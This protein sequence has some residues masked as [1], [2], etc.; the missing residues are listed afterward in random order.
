MNIQ[1][2][3]FNFDDQALQNNDIFKEFQF[4]GKKYF[5][6]FNSNGESILFANDGYSVNKRDFYNIYNYGIQEL[7][8]KE[9]LL[10]GLGPGSLFQKDWDNDTDFKRM[11][12]EIFTEIEDI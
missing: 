5:I 2:P 1:K 6:T 10:V 9:N 8:T 4:E 7:K 3:I 11:R 12:I